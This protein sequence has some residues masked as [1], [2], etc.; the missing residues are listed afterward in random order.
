M[1]A[2]PATHL[3]ELAVADQYRNIQLMPKA[4]ARVAICCFDPRSPVEC[5]TLNRLHGELVRISQPEHPGDHQTRAFNQPVRN[6]NDP[7][8]RAWPD[9]AFTLERNKI[10]HR[11]KF[12]ADVCYTAEPRTRHGD[13]NR[14]GHRDHLGDI[15]QRDQ[16]VLRAHLKAE[17]DAAVFCDARSR[18]RC[19]TFC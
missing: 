2:C 11:V 10:H 5:F 8:F 3:Q 14:I 15:R 17:L 7:P 9:C 12:S 13:G 4:T 16:P 1:F 18:M 19:A 6:Q